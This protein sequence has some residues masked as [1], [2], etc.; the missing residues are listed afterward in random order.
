MRPAPLLGLAIQI[1][2]EPG[3]F[4]GWVLIVAGGVLV[5]WLL[6]RKR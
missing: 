6:A 2:I 5:L 4:L 1:V 3:F